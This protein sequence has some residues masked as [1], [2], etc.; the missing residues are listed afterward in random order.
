MYGIIRSKMDGSTALVDFDH[1]DDLIDYV[2][3]NG[4]DPSC[5]LWIDDRETEETLFEYIV[6]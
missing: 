4:I 3:D 5:T 1:L 6:L 2:L